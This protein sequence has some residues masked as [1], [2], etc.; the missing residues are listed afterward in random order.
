MRR[1]LIAQQ[2]WGGPWDGQ[3][4][5]RWEPCEQTF[6]V[7]SGTYVLVDQWRSSDPIT[8][9]TARYDWAPDERAT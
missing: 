4:F 1:Q 2:F 9:R 8:Q 5:E 7:S 6:V 3:R